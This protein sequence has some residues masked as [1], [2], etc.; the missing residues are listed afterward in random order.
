MPRRKTQRTGCDKMALDML[1]E[2]LISKEEA[3]TRV[4]PSQLDELLHP[5]I[6]P[7]AELEQK[8]LAKGLPAGPGGAS[9]QIVFSS[10]DAVLWENKA[11]K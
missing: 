5:V 6:D 9:G 2:K 1:K 3:V 11:K 10:N 4:T 7:R 8:P